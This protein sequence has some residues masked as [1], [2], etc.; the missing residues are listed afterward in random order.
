MTLVSGHKGGYDLTNTPGNSPLGQDDSEVLRPEQFSFT[1]TEY[2]AVVRAPGQNT[3]GSS[4]SSATEPAVRTLG[5]L[6]NLLKPQFP[7]LVKWT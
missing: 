5:R 4:L 6:L 3:M 1:L 2:R 7:L